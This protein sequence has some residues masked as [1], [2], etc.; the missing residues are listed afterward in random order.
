MHQGFFRHALKDTDIW[1]VCVHAL[2]YVLWIDVGPG[3]T[4]E[5]V[6][7]LVFVCF[8]VLLCWKET[9]QGYGKMRQNSVYYSFLNGR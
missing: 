1:V 8:F 3:V 6:S 2:N 9:T 5:S 4:R 7:L